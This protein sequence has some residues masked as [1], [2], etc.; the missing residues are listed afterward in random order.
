MGSILKNTREGIFDLRCREDKN[1]SFYLLLHNCIYVH[2]L[3]SM[4]YKITPPTI[5]KIIDTMQIHL[6]FL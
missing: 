2:F 4:K 6:S 1:A 5:S 3:E